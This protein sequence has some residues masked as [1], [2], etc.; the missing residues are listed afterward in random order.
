MQNGD[1]EDGNKHTSNGLL[2]QNF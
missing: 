2:I 1:Q